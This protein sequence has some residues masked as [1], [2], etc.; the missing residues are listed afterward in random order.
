MKFISCLR[1]GRETWGAAVNDRFIDARTILNDR[2]KTLEEFVSSSD[3]A[4]REVL[5]RPTESSLPLGVISYLPV[6]TKP[7]KIILVARN[8][9]EHHNEAVAAGLKREIS[10]YPPIFLRVWRSQVGHE[11]PLIRPNVSQ[12][13]DWE[14]ELAVIIGKTGRHISE[15]DALE[16]VAGY[17]AYNDASVRDWQFHAQQ[18]AAGKNFVGTGAFGP[19]MVTPDEIG[20]P[21]TLKIE[22]RVNGEVVQ[23]SNTRHLIFGIPR[24]INYISTI[25]DLI[26]GDVI[27]T[28]TP[29]GV[30][31]ARKPPRYLVPGDIVEVEVEKIGVLRNPVK[32]E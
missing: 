7:E 12:E 13:L 16:H 15:K 1:D 22:T 8:Y 10:K 25:F 5:F 4:D 21:S 24:L 32:D 19:W 11:T 27:V 6:I 30:G 23:S 14:G 20:D 9:L 31:F 2:H 29:S 28:G 26:P 3:Y 18:I 17:S